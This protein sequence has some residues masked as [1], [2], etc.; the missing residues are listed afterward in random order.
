MKRIYW[1]CAEFLSESQIGIG[2]K[3][4][5]FPDLLDPEDYNFSLDD[6]RI[7]L[8]EQIASLM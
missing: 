2:L 6:H 7:D 5:K 1:R 4:E 8:T 3:P